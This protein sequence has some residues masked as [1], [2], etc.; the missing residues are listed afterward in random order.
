MQFLLD[1]F[2]ASNWLTKVQF[3]INARNLTTEKEKPRLLFSK[4][5][6]LI[7]CLRN[8]KYHSYILVDVTQRWYLLRWYF[9][10]GAPTKKTK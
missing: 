8:G 3:K 2:V 4:H 10:K 5:W 6:S 1:N 9:D 7:F